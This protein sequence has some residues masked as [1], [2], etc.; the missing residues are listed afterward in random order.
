MPASRLYPPPIS[1]K[2][3]LPHALAQW[4]NVPMSDWYGD[5][6]RAPQSDDCV[7]LPAVFFKEE[8]YDNRSIYRRWKTPTYH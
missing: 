1:V 3:R 5:V 2:S 4:Y 6:C 8:A 7:C